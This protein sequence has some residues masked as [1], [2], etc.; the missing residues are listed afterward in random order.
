M[1]ALLPIVGGILA[2]WLAPRRTAIVLQIVFWAVAVVMLTLSAP[3]HG[4]SYGDVILIAPALAAVS[5]ATLWFGLWLS[6]RR[7]RTA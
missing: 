5:A 7:T 1:F 6:R 2:G 3:D 4:A